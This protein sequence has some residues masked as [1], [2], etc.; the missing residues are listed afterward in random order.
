LSGSRV[1]PKAPVNIS[2]LLRQAFRHHQSGH[3]SRAAKL[4]ATVLARQPTH[5]DALHLLGVLNYQQGN[6]AQALAYIGAALRTNSRSAEGL[7]N[8]GLV[9]H[10]LGRY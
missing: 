8:H 1:S 6:M 4:Y 5:F 2:R 9:L 7:S 10:E 3:L